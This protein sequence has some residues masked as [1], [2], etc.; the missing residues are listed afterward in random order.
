MRQMQKV[1]WSKGVLLSPQHLQTQDRFFEDLIGFQL[2]GFLAFPWGF[3]S[4]DLDHEA[5]QSGTLALSAASGILPDGL[6]FDMP[7]EDAPPPPRPLE[8]SWKP[9]QSSLLAYLAIPEH[10]LGGRNVSTGHQNQDTRF[11]AELLLR[12][13]ENTGTQEKPIQVARKNFRFLVEGEPAE[14]YTSLPVARIQRSK[15]GEL[16]FDARFVPPSWKSAPAAISWPRHDASWR[17]SR[18]EAASYPGCVA[19]GA[20]TWRTSESPM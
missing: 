5:L 14:G 19:R 11:I 2:S 3:S 8:G 20:K 9:D 7:A 18:R 6:L 12:R 4:L 16:R 17:S 15:A 1:L 10:R 13:D